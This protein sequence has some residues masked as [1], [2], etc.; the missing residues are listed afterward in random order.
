MFIKVVSIVPSLQECLFKRIRVGN[1]V[2]PAEEPRIVDS[3]VPSCFI[4]WSR[5]LVM[6]VH[7]VVSKDW[8]DGLLPED[9]CQ[10]YNHLAVCVKYLLLLWV[11]CSCV[12]LAETMSHHVS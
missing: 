1:E 2:F 10:L 4:L 12:F 8:E 5:S 3:C 7:I 9:H 11:G 6:I